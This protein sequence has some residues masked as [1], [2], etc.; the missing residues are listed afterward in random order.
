MGSPNINLVNVR[1]LRN[2]RDWENSHKDVDAPELSL[3]D[4]SRNIDIIEEWLRGCLGVSNIPLAYV[5]RSEELMPAATPAGGYQSLQ[6]KLIARAPIRVGN[7]GNA[8]YTADY[9]ANRSKVWE[10][11]SDITQDQDF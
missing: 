4:W 3:W 11:I 10:L 2:H 5:F 8:A 7:A 6:D 1:E 9:L